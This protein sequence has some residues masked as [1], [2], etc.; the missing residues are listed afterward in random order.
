V[1]DPFD[2]RNCELAGAMLCPGGLI[3]A[4][5]RTITSSHRSLVI[6]Y[7]S[8]TKVTKPLITSNSADSRY[9]TPIQLVLSAKNQ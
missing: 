4:T 5:Y 6:L 2:Y 7:S 9:I 1:D 3:N 8:G